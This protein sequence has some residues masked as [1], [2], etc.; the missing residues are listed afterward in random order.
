MF[1][2]IDLE[3]A[4]SDLYDVGVNDE[5]LALICKANHEIQMAVKTPSGLT[6]R[7]A[8]YNCVL[9]GDTFGSILSSVQVDTIGKECVAE[10]HTYLYKEKLPV[11]FL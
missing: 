9:Q 3:K 8:I 11:G 2:S 10:G 5:S 1:D 7:Q 4:L 6:N